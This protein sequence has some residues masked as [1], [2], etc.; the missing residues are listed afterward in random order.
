MRPVRPKVVAPVRWT[1]RQSTDRVMRAAQRPRLLKERPVCGYL[2]VYGGQ[3]VRRRCAQEA[4][5]GANLLVWRL[6]AALAQLATPERIQR[7]GLLPVSVTVRS[8]S[9]IIVSASGRSPS[10]SALVER[11]VNSYAVTVASV[12]RSF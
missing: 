6:H 12:R 7:V 9:C 5:E 3:V 2:R 8:N 4:K 1:A 11:F 10:R